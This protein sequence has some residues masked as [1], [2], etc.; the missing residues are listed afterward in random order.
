MRLLVSER[1]APENWDARLCS[2]GGSVF[3]S[4]AWAQF[5]EAERPGAVPQF[6]TFVGADG[7]GAGF[8]LGFVS[9]SPRAAL[10]PFTGQLTLDAFPAFRGGD[11]T[12]LGDAL[13]A[14]E[15]H[16]RSLGATEVFVGSYGSPGGSDALQRLGFTL[17]RR[18]EFELCLDRP[19]RELWDG[20]E[21]KR[22]RNIKK[23]MQHGVIIEDL[24]ATVG[25]LELRRLQAASAERIVQRGGPRI[26]FAGASRDDPVRALLNTGVAR[27]VGAKSGSAVVSAVLFTCFNGLVYHHLSGHDHRALETQAPTLL[28]WQAMNRY[29][30][31]GAR[32]FNF[33]GCKLDALNPQ[34]SEHGVYEYKKAFGGTVLRCASGSKALR[35]TARRVV[36]ILERVSRWV[37]A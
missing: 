27:I 31:E 14:V 20:L 24:P 9:R 15:C 7:G 2:V 32:C 10:R 6:L 30:E 22:R 35:P 18:L 13:A 36:G 4:S 1:I 37:T 16:A 29:R 21:S 34:S 25:L 23:A 11:E 3:H 19:E 28:F 12:G 8:A 5:V 33:G 17:T 26:G